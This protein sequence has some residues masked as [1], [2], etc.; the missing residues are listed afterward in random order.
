M[1]KACELPHRPWLDRPRSAGRS[2]RP[3]MMPLTLWMGFWAAMGGS[4]SGRTVQPL[5]QPSAQ[6]GVGLVPSCVPPFPLTAVSVA[7]MVGGWGGKGSSVFAS[8]EYLS[9]LVWKRTRT[10]GSERKERN[11]GEKLL[12]PGMVG[13]LANEMR[14]FRE[15]RGGRR[16]GRWNVGARWIQ[17]MQVVMDAVEKSSKETRRVRESL[18]NPCVL[19]VFP[20]PRLSSH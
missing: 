9:F 1:A 16:S 15:V 12:G 7:I 10:G 11:A 4:T 3:W 18:C 20:N 5:L 6:A 17:V 2:S 19:S 14:I 13:S 8:E